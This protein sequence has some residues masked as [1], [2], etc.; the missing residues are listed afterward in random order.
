VRAYQSQHNMMLGVEGEQKFHIHPSHPDYKESSQRAVLVMGLHNE[1]TGESGCQ[2]E[3]FGVK[4][5]SSVKNSGELYPR[6][7]ATPVDP[8]YRVNVKAGQVALLVFGAGIHR[9]SKQGVAI[10]GHF[11]DVAN[12]RDAQG[13]FLGNTEEYIL[14]CGLPEASEDITLKEDGAIISGLS[15]LPTSILQE[16][17]TGSSREMKDAIHK[18]G[19]TRF[20]AEPDKRSKIPSGATPHRITKTVNKLRAVAANSSVVPDPMAAVS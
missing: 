12:D 9:F 14:D 6:C 3:F 19:S 8:L 13:S 7:S 20:C 15:D 11:F 17:F 1:E 4:D 18:H 16:I 2:F 10:S 5:V